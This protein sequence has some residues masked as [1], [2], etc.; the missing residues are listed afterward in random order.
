MGHEVSATC[1]Y[2]VIFDFTGFLPPIDNP[3]TGKMNGVKAGSSVP[4]KFR[5]GGFQGLGVLAA[6]YPKSA[7]FPC[8]SAPVDV[9]PD[10]DLVSI[11]SASANGL[12]Y[13]ML[14]QEYSYVW[15]TD[16][17]WAGKCRQLVVKFI[18]GQSRFVNFKAMK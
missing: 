1:A 17:A 11:F 8:G 18:D 3:V 16:K 7:E 14:S 10:G 6:G 5:L 12:S 15:K 13:D 4:V 9:V 2:S